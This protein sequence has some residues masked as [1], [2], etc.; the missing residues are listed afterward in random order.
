MRYSLYFV[1]LLLLSSCAIAPLTQGGPARPLGEKKWEAGLQASTY[2]KGNGSLSILPVARVR[3]GLSPRWTL[4]SYTEGSTVSLSGHYA[5]WLDEPFSAAVEI[6]VAYGGGS[7]SYFGGHSL[8]LLKGSWEPFVS[9]QVFLAN[10]IPGNWDSTFFRGS[11][12]LHPVFFTLALGTR[13]WVTDDI[14]L[15]FHLTA[16]LSSRSISFQS[17]LTQNISLLFHW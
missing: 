5:Y 7:M 1:G 15:S 14:A 3:Y 12:S 8:S 17:P 16:L 10:L 6:G 9:T 4:A 13:F 11:P 2:R